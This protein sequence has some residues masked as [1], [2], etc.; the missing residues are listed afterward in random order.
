M[1]PISSRLLWR[2]PAP[3]FTQR[4]NKELSCDSNTMYFF[5]FAGSTPSPQH[6]SSSTN[7]AAPSELERAVSLSSSLPLSKLWSLGS[8]SSP[9]LSTL[10]ESVEGPSPAKRVREIGT[11]V[12]DRPGSPSWS[13]ERVSTSSPSP[14][15]TRRDSSDRTTGRTRFTWTSASLVSR[16][17]LIAQ[18]RHTSSAFTGRTVWLFLLSYRGECSLQGQL[19]G[20][21]SLQVTAGGSAV[22]S[23]SAAT[24]T[25]S[26]S[27]WS[28]KSVPSSTVSDSESCKYDSASASF[29]ICRRN[30][31]EKSVSGL[32]SEAYI[33]YLP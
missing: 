18:R 28:R 25:T 4:E 17:R 3:H 11:G 24:S 23:G 19:Q 12:D 16:R 31:A 26:E 29:N 10:E 6:S 20:Q 21:A 5:S 30:K 32:L 8:V 7:S 14:D 9:W 13:V 2:T 22:R 15:E 1:E 33:N 27:A